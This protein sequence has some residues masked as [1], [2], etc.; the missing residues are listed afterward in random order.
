MWNNLL[1]LV[2]FVLTFKKKNEKFVRSSVFYIDADIH[3]YDYSKPHTLIAR[4]SSIIT[5]SR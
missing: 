5:F 1:F 4:P 2:N 3:N